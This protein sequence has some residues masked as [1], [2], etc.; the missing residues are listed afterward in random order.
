MRIISFFVAK[1]KK[2]YLHSSPFYLNLQKQP[3]NIK[4]Q[5][6]LKGTVENGKVETILKNYNWKTTADLINFSFFTSKFF[7]E[8]DRS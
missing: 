6:M 2:E 7:H 8:K 3:C 1:N 4:V 5:L